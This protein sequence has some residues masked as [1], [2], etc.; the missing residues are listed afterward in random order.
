MASKISFFCHFCTHEVSGPTEGFLADSGTHVPIWASKLIARKSL[1]KRVFRPD[2]SSAIRWT[3]VARESAF[4]IVSSECV[5]RGTS[6]LIDCPAPLALHG[7]GQIGP[8]RP[9]Q[10]VR[11]IL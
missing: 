1:S 9:K 11:V 5:G 2:F 8:N 3:R 6:R 10:D 4:G 7:S